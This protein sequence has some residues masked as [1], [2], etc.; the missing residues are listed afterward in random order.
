MPRY[1]FDQA[2]IAQAHHGFAHRR[3]AHVEQFGQ[4]LFERPKTGRPDIIEN[5]PTHRLIRQLD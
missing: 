1:H 4:F 5:A 2:I 3:A